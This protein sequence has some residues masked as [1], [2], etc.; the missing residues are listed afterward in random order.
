MRNKDQ[1]DQVRSWSDIKGDVRG[2]LGRLRAER[3][4]RLAQSVDRKAVRGTKPVHG[5]ASRAGPVA[6]TTSAAQSVDHR[7][8]LTER[9]QESRRELAGLRQSRRRRCEAS[10]EPGKPSVTEPIRPAG[11][12]KPAVARQPPARIVS[13]KP[14]PTPAP[15]RGGIPATAA[16]KD[17]KN[18][19][20]RPAA[21]VLA[22]QGNRVNRLSASRDID[23]LRS[24]GPA[25]KAKLRRLN[26]K[27]VGELARQRPDDLRVLLGPA[28]RLI[29]LEAIVASARSQGS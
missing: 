21:A 19:Q 18:D 22:G 15:R 10:A 11:S 25:L 6:S 1:D 17:P 9:M 4:A 12:Q 29:N 7:Q 27:T 28:S 24:L 3:L 14:A 2:Y 5:A 16:K 20:A 23:E 26:I 13:V 8:I